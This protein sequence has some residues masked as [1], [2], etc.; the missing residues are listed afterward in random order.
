M[1][2]ALSSS[3]GPH[4]YWL[5][6][7]LEWEGL[8]KRIILAPVSFPFH[9]TSAYHQSD[10]YQIL[11][12]AVMRFSIACGMH[13]ISDPSAQMN[14]WSGLLPPPTD[15]VDL[16]ERINLWW[17]IYQLDRGAAVGSGLPRS[18]SDDVGTP[19]MN[20]TVIFCLH[21][22]LHSE[23]QRFGLNHSAHSKSHYLHGRMHQ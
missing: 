8:S 22:L 19:D 9:T 18:V 11:I 3:C 6:I 16:F 13:E 1:P 7:I 23:L 20:G 17:G 21:T 12:Q 10:G 4:Y 14:E 2:T 15:I 5:G